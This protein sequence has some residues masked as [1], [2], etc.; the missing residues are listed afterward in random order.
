MHSIS[1][2][3]SFVNRSC[4]YLF[5]AHSFIE[6]HLK[7]FSSL[8]PMQFPTLSA[9]LKDFININNDIHRVV[10]VLKYSEVMVLFY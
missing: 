6:L 8:I 7:Y 3:L 2:L 9:P 1:F 10:M 5:D 4:H